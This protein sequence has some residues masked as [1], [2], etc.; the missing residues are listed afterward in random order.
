MLDVS[1][2]EY[3]D[4]K[5]TVLR[6]LKENRLRKYRGRF[7]LPQ[8]RATKIPRTK[9]GFAR[10]NGAARKR[11]RPAMPPAFKPASPE[12]ERARGLSELISEYDLRTRFPEAVLA[13]CESV[14][15]RQPAAD[16]ERVDLAGLEILCIDPVDARDH[17]DAI[18]LENLPD[19][20]RRLGVHIADVAE[21]VD[22]GSALDRE[23]RRRGNSTYFYLDTLPMLPPLL[24]GQIC[25]LQEG[26]PRAALSLFI[27]FD[28]KGRPGAIELCETRLLVSRSLSYEE[29]ETYLSTH[30]AEGVTTALGAMRELSRQL[31]GHRNAGGALQFDL[32]ETRPVDKGDGVESFAP[33]PKLDSHGIVEEFMLAANQAVGRLSRRRG[34][35]HLNRVHDA[36]DPEDVEELDAYLSH[37]KVGWRPGRPVSNGDYQR[38]TRSLDKHPQRERLL[39][40][41]L[42]SF[43]KAVYEAEDGGHFGLA[44]RDY[45][46]FTSPIRRYADLQLHRSLKD[47]LAIE[48]RRAGMQGRR[49]LRLEPGGESG[50]ARHRPMPRA[51]VQLARHLSDREINSLRAERDAM[52]LE[53]VLWARQHLGE[54]FEARVLSVFPTGLLLRLPASGV[55]GFMPA[56]FLGEEW[57]HHDE[58]RDVLRGERTGKV[59]AEDDRLQV[60]LA[61][62]SLFTRRIQFFLEDIANEDDD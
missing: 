3:R 30:D 49:T 34:L 17:D 9:S 48:S 7:L 39:Y 59:F 22:A 47:L 41:M 33:V 45:L 6:M 23:A 57:F 13:E 10:A 18:S 55:D 25:S 15:K 53:M 26:E 1:R 50:P 36:P 27:D 31:A 5:R 54:S 61:G 38:L 32:P 51:L 42:R 35:P 62:A 12:T 40:R 20:I 11:R 52:R 56:Q 58:E 46:H 2:E 28:S 37:R 24:S 8:A 19:G 4:F 29:A 60:R 21:F 43:Q 16:D 14:A 44:W